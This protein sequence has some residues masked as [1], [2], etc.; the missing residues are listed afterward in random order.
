MKKSQNLAFSLLFVS[1]IILVA[2]QS[3]NNHTDPNKNRI[4]GKCYGLALS[5]GADYGPY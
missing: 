4:E 1:F 3:H 5:E 2:A